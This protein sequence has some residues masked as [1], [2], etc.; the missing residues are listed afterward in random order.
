MDAGITKHRLGNMLSYDWLKIIAAI[1]AAV[2]ALVAFFTT[3][4]PRPGKYR[5]FTVYGYSE[6]RMGDFDLTDRL[7]GVFSYDVLKIE[8]ETFGKEQYSETAFTA[9]RSAGQGTV[10]FTTTNVADGEEETGKTVLETLTAGD[11]TGLALDVEQYLADCERYLIRFFGEDWRTG[12]LREEEARECFLNRNAKDNRYRRAEKREEGV[13]DEFLRL[14]RLREDYIA[15]LGHFDAGK[16]GFVYVA[17]NEERAY[18]SAISL[19]K[20]GGLKNL[21]YYWDESN[22]GSVMTSENVCLLLFRNDED[23]GRPA[24]ETENDLRY[25]AV[26]FLDFLVDQFS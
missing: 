2:L 13:R 14:E 8:Y 10:M 20:L 21:V 6:I 11:M 26:S 15:L 23:A 22:G 9:R 16:L 25:E 24:D 19:A 5:I 18:A 7:A 12:Q 1:L 4:K 17:D 3:V